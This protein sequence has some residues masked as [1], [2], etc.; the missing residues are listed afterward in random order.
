MHT[1]IL[2]TKNTIG[3]HQTLQPLK[4]PTLRRTINGT[5]LDIAPGNLDKY[6]STITASEVPLEAL[7]PYIVGDMVEVN[8]L[9]RLTESLEP[10]PH[11]TRLK[12]PPLLKT[13]CAFEENAPQKLFAI[14]E[15]TEDTR[16]IERPEALRDGTRVYASYCPILTMRVIAFTY[17]H[18]KGRGT[19]HWHL[20]LEEV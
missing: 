9:Q 13:L 6:R 11:K 5:L 1:L 14:K 4:M 12:R 7:T 15:I 18:E 3:Y 2:N 16:E 19:V 20:S 17:T 8:C 10:A